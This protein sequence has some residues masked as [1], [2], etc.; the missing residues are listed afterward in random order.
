MKQ[1]LFIS[2]LFLLSS[3]AT[4]QQFMVGVNSF[5][6]TSNCAPKTFIIM[7]GNK[8]T[9]VNDLEFQEYCIYVERALINNGLTKEN[10]GN[11]ADIIVFLAYGIGEPEEHGYTYSIPVFGQTGVSSSNTT[12]NI[13]AFGNTG[14]YSAKTTYTPQYG[15]TGFRTGQGS[16][17]T[18]SRYIYLSAYDLVGYRSSKKAIIVWDT[19]I[20]SIG[21]SG[22]LR[23]VFPVMIAA[24]IDYIGKNTKGIKEITLTEEDDSVLFIK[25]DAA[26]LEE[27]KSSRTSDW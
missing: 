9:D 23:R 10:D 3:C 27:S 11:E 17:T 12:G 21:S 16:Y 15:I 13:I 18:F 2:L 14:M 5:S 7:P 20:A 19:R 25:G 6:R 4:T 26:A 8:N 22:D 24:S 1:L